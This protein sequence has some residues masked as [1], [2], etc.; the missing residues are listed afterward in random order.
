MTNLTEKEKVAYAGLPDPGDL[1]FGITLKDMERFDR[2]QERNR[3]YNSP[4]RDVEKETFW[5]V[6]DAPIPKEYD[7]FTPEVLD[8]FR[9]RF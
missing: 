2:K 6:M 3:V 4:V 8:A 1:P 7:I 5:D 9:K